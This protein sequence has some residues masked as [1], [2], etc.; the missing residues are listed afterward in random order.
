MN[1]KLIAF[2][3]IAALAVSACTK[4]GSDEP[5]P[6]ADGAASADS[7]TPTDTAP[8]DSAPPTKTASE[9]DHAAPSTGLDVKAFAGNFS[10]DD[11]A[12]ELKADG[13][14]TLSGDA[15]PGTSDGTW[16]AEEDG[17]RIRL[18]PN[19]KGEEDWLFAVNS[20]DEL[21][22]LDEQGNPPE[23]APAGSL[24]RIKK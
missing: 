12:L 7:T 10:G 14:Y 21:Q 9:L 4:P 23:N 20:N 15:L 3:C 18:D 19:K 16:A 24:A 5:E 11:I 6:A 22:A 13:S 1:K 17:K 8:A 2:A